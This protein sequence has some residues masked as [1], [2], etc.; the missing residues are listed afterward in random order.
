[1]RKTLG[2]LGNDAKLHKCVARHAMTQVDQRLDQ[3]RIVHR[4]RHNSNPA[5]ATV[6]VAQPKAEPRPAYSTTRQRQRRLPF[7]ESLVIFDVAL[8]LGATAAAC[9]IWPVSGSAL[10][11]WPT[12][13]AGIVWLGAL[14]GI[15]GF[16]TERL[17]KPFP[18][19]SVWRSRISPTTRAGHPVASCST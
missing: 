7:I 14:A 4:A 17:V 5:P 10:G 2:K 15:K 3:R 12:I 13:I 9:L 18:M 6:N 16:A 11:P 19:L 8:V 1:M